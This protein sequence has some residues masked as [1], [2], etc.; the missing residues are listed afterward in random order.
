MMSIVWAGGDFSRL[1]LR[2]SRVWAWR[3]WRIVLLVGRA[4]LE[5][6]AAGRY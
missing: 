2:V 4:A 6:R 5:A 3:T 1:P